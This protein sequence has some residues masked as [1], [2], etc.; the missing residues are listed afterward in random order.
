MAVQ[1][2]GW[3]RA[4]GNAGSGSSRAAGGHEN[5]VL[6]GEGGRQQGGRGGWVPRVGP[7]GLHG[8]VGRRGRGRG[9]GV[10]QRAAHLRWRGL[11]PQ[12]NPH[13]PGCA[14]AS[15]RGTQS[16]RLLYCHGQRRGHSGRPSRLPWRQPPAKYKRNTAGGVEL[17][18]GCCSPAAGVQGRSNAVEWWSGA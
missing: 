12:Q 11:T 17:L 8:G 1:E 7:Y 18:L 5:H 10:Q 13:P 3:V 16:G 9:S 6:A 15:C 4:E 2:H 14:S